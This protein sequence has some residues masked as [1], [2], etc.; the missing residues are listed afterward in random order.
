MEKR[1]LLMILDGFGFSEKHEHNA[2]FLAEKPNLDRLMRTCPHSLI[3]TSGKD[4]GLPE[5]VMGN[6]EVGHLNMGS[7]RI[8]K[9][10]LT[11]ITDFASENGFESLPDVERLFS[12]K[13]GALH[14]MGLLS[15]GSVH[16]HEGHLFALLEAAQRV[17]CTRPIF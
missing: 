13:V 12:D 5:G 1:V 6:S 16:S 15:D 10:E 2:I 7:G 17:K 11:K 9:Q 4:V 14:I 3:G 8:L